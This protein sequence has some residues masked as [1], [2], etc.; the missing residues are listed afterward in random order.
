MSEE[1]ETT[2]HY[3][4]T[5]KF[6]FYPALLVAASLGAAAVL[7]LIA[8]GTPVSL[9][10]VLSNPAV[11]G[12]L[13][14]AVAVIPAFFLSSV[15][16]VARPGRVRES[17]VFVGDRCVLAL[18]AQENA[19]YQRVGE[20][21]GMGALEQE[22][23]QEDIRTIAGSL[24]RGSRSVAEWLADLSAT[25][26]Q[27]AYRGQ[28]FRDEDLW[29]VLEEPTV[30]DEARAAAALLLVREPS[31]AETDTKARIRVAASDVASPHLRVAIERLLDTED[32]IDTD[33]FAALARARRRA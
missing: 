22:A 9:L 33:A 10:S 21:G 15:F 17:G 6:A 13:F 28:R 16:F 11:L 29:S 27:S 25:Q 30:P 1:L 2:V 14:A 18:P 20:R 26:G 31:T 32:A 3:R 7:N 5:A 4:N 19:S 24:V 23:A 8:P 12:G